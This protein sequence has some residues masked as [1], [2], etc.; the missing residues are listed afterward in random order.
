MSQQ[1]DRA[2]IF[3]KQLQALKADAN[4]TLDE[5]QLTAAGNG[6][7]PKVRANVQEFWTVLES[8]L[9]W[10]QEM[11]RSRAY[12]FVQ[13]EVVPRRNAAGDLLRELA[14]V[15]E[16]VLKNSEAEFARSRRAAMLWLSGVVAF[17]VLL[18]LMVA[19]FSLSYAGRLEREGL[20]RFEEVTQAKK[21]LEQLS[22]RLLE[23]QEDER[24]RLSRELHD[25]IGQTLTA[26]RIEISHALAGWR[27]LA[28][29][30]G[31]A[32]ASAGAGGE[33]TA[34][35]AQHLSAAQAG[36]AG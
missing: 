35:G 14:T 26:L 29:D 22:A 25:E 6:S 28:R 9:G 30:T 7:F 8:T 12:Q 15:N 36:T 13:S 4:A 16:S 34:I 31:P 32:G 11:R 3:R 33:D 19:R 21:D 18:G 5:L 24:K 27:G 23:I 1:G 2:E 10:T 17:S 20:R